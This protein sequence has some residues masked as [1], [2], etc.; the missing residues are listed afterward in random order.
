[1]QTALPLAE[2][3][4]LGCLTKGVQGVNQ[5]RM[6]KRRR[7]RIEQ[8]LSIHTEAVAK[9]L[10]AR[11]QTLPCKLRYVEIRH[12]QA[13]NWTLEAKWQQWVEGSWQDVPWVMLDG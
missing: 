10:A 3:F 6:M 13:Q 11:L 5:T 8:P 7:N 1:M 12:Y 4:W 2:F 9:Q